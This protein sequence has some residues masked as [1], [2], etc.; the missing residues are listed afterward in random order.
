MNRNEFIKKIENERDFLEK[1][2]NKLIASIG[3]IPIANRRIM[4]FGWRKSAKGRT[5][6]RILEEII[7]QNL[8]LHAKDY[9]LDEALPAD[10]E[11]GVYDFKFIYNHELE[12]YVNIKSSVLGGKR[13]K[14]DISKAE[15]IRDFFVSNNEHNLYIATFVINFKNDMTIELVKC[16]VMPITWI[17]D[18]YVNPSNNGNLQSADYKNLNAAIKRTNEEFLI[19][20]EQAYNIA[21]QKKTKKIANI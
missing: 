2:L 12:S 3:P 8:E 5:V 16:I 20:F 19:E 17:P 10:S 18:I 21:K 6:W 14:D 11:V 1:T 7:S 13:N 9:G 4:P 15:G